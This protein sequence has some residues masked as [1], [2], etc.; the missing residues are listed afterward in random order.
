MAGFI[1]GGREALLSSWRAATVVSTVFDCLRVMMSLTQGDS[2]PMDSTTYIAIRQLE[3]QFDLIPLNI[4][5]LHLRSHPSFCRIGLPRPRPYIKVVC[6]STSR[7]GAPGGRQGGKRR[8]RYKQLFAVGLSARGTK[9]RTL[10][11]TPSTA[12]GS[13]SSYSR[14]KSSL[15]K[16]WH[17]WEVGS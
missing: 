11:T 1:R 14:V 7:R 2:V 8:P 9:Q 12:R 4:F 3:N 6:H 5:R 16:R 10:P 13:G 17:D 15:E